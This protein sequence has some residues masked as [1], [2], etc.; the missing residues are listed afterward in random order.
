VVI[1][2]YIACGAVAVNSVSQYAHS[3]QST[4]CVCWNDKYVRK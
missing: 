4:V 2:S 1:G 3:K